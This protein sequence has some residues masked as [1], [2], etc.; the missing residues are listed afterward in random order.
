MVRSFL[1]LINEYSKKM[2]RSAARYALYGT[3]FVLVR[4]PYRMVRAVT[5]FLI[6]LGLM[7][8]VRQKKMAQESLEFALGQ[9]K[10]SQEIQKILKNCFVNLGK[11]IIE[12]IYFMAHPKMIKIGRAHV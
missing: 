2:R 5:G 7:T 8:L 11:G 3:S 1:M 10:T 6:S 4:L 9:E 12:L